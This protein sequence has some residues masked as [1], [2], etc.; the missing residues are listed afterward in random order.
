MAVAPARTQ[1]FHVDSRQPARPRV[2]LADDHPAVLLAVARFLSENGFDVVA[3]AAD[4]AEALDAVE[5]LAPDLALVDLRMPRLDGVE[6]V[7][8]LRAR[9]P[10]TRVAVYTAEATPD[11][12][13]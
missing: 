11:L 13:R 8:Q 2:V 10:G 9:C 6:L 3:T 4:G 12:A 7:R 5:R 1:A